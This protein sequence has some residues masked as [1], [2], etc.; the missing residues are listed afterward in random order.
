[1]AQWFVVGGEVTSLGGELV[2]WWRDDQY[3]VSK[4]LSGRS[5]FLSNPFF[6]SSG[7]PHPLTFSPLPKHRKPRR[8]QQN[9]LENGLIGSM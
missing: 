9:A 5:G 3:L 6:K 2:S 7:P 8:V 4:F 1:M